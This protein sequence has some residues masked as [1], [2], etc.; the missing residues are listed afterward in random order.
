MAIAGI[1]A[2]LCAASPALVLGAG[3]NS[4]SSD[5]KG[6]NNVEGDNKGTIVVQ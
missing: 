2:P 1:L 3:N 4:L 5:F 6:M